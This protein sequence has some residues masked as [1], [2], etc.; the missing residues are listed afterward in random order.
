MPK[1]VSEEEKKLIK[2][3]IYENT[4]RLIQ[5]KGVRSVT[6]DQIAAL[7]GIAKGSFYTYYSSK[8]ACLY[9]TLKRS[10]KALFARM[11]EVMA[12]KLDTRDKA[13]A[14]LWEVFLAPESIVMYLNPCDLEALLRKLPAEYR[15]REQKKS[16]DYF[17][18]SL[19]LLG[20]SLEKM[21]A[22]ALMTDSLNLVAT[23]K[24]YSDQS[25][26]DALRVLVNAIPDYAAEGEKPIGNIKL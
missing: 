12:Q 16:K 15:A 21:E 1:V 19:A 26:A 13:A 3:S 25:K 4:L 8:E 11:E 10:E 23:S 9:E 20:V 5:E 22:I 17:Q 18:K 24:E 6:V 7:S 2:E 14:V